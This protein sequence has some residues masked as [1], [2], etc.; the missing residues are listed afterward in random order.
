M[1]TFKTM[2]NLALLL[3]YSDPPSY[4]PT[5]ASK[6]AMKMKKISNKKKKNT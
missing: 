4:L 6:K 3:L 5:V 2:M 1:K